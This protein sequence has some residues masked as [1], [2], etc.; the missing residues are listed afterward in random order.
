MR[1]NPLVTA[2]NTARKPRAY[3]GRSSLLTGTIFCAA[4]L[5]AQQGISPDEVRVSSRPYFP[6]QPMI[7]VQTTEVRVAAVVRDARLKPVIGLQKQDFEIYDQ[8][9][10]QT[11][12]GFSVLAAALGQP[13]EHGLLDRCQRIFDSATVREIPSHDLP[14]AAVDHTHQVCPANRRPCPDLCHIGLP[15]LIW[16]GCIHTA[17]LFLPLC[18]QAARAYQHPTL[19]HHSQH[20]LAIHGEIFFSPQ[21][22]GHPPI[23]IGRCFS[24]RHDDLLTLPWRRGIGFSES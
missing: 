13:F 9:K 11:I 12:S 3:L 6:N 15:D 18:P 10:K 8:G 4:S 21:P 22:P 5:L 17:P 19:A 1:S 16:F 20:T 24:A 7:R 23:S 2:E 14:R